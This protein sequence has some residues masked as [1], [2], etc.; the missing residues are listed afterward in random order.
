MEIRNV[1][2]IGGGLMGRQI[3][4][5]AAIYGYQ[6]KLTDNYA[7]VLTAVREWADEYLAGRIAKGRMTAE[8]VDDV[9]AHFQIVEDIKTAVC[10]ADLVIEAVVEKA[11]VK[12]AVFKEVAQY[13]PAEA[14][15]ATNSSRMPSSTFIESVR[16]PA[17]LANMHYNNPALVM[18]LVEVQIHEQTSEDTAQTLMDFCTKNGKTPVLIR[19]EVEGMIVSRILGAINR[20]AMFLVE[21]GYVTVEDVDKA[22]MGG[23]SHP[24]GPFRLMDL[25]GIDLTH[26]ILT[27]RY[28]NEGVKPI[29]YDLTKSYVDKGWCGKK[30][31]RGFYDYSEEK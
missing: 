11:D 29:G 5:N 27:K 18:K 17:K 12:N 15:M 19:K 31:G 16:D 4:L 28:E 25:T 8:K 14:I 26:T 7:P 23:L 20:E 6:V 21:G 30:T 13:A 2:V 24:M 10:D 1:A 3:A 22:C 9:K